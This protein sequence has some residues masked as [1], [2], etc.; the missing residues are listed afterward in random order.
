MA[1]VAHEQA[2]PHGGHVAQRPRDGQGRAQQHREGTRVA[3]VVHAGGVGAGHVEHRHEHGRHRGQPQGHAEE[4]VLVVAARLEAAQ[5]DEGPQQAELHVHAQ[6]PQ[7]G[8]GRD[9]ADLVEV[10][11][12][13][14]DVVPVVEEQQAR[15]DVGAHLGEGHVVEDDA[16]G[17][18]NGHHRGQRGPQALDASAPE[19]QQVHVARAVE[20][21]QQRVGHEVAREHEEH[22]DAHVAARQPSHLQVVG[23][24]RGDGQGAQALD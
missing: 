14:C 5:R 7:V 20:L 16:G 19:R 23:H 17:A 6:V 15:Q 2:A 22:D 9:A 10:R 8:E 1:H 24:D 13:A 12:A 3:A 4:H 11:Q 18:H 21:A